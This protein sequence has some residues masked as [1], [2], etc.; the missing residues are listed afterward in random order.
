M[1]CRQLYKL[2]DEGAVE[3]NRTEFMIK[4][5]ALLTKM[6]EKGKG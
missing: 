4:D 5:R 6:A 1:V 3:V 2:A